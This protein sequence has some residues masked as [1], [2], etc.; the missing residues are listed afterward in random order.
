[1]RQFF[2]YIILSTLLLGCSPQNRNEVQSVNDVLEKYVQTS[3]D[4]KAFED[5]TR[6]LE[7]SSGSVKRDLEA[8]DEAG[9][10]RQFADRERKLLKFTIRDRHK[11]SPNRYS[12][13]YEVKLTQALS[14]KS[15]TTQVNKKLAFLTN[16][17]GKWLIDEVRNIN[18]TI[19]YKDDL[20]VVP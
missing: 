18:S 17:Q 10:K 3:F 5:R 4:L 9:F 13:L 6:L 12:V 7:L 16:D 2:Q 15:L 8:M 1:M 19:S 11:L 14:D 20:T